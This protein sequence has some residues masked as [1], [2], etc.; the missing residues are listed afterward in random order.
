MINVN[1]N[2]KVPEAKPIDTNG[3]GWTWGK[4]FNNEPIYYGNKFND[5]L[6]CTLIIEMPEERTVNWI[7]YYPY[8]P[9]SSCYVIINDISTSI[10]NSTDYKTCIIDVGDRNARIGAD[11]VP[12]LDV[13]DRQKYKGHGVWVFPARTAKFIKFE[14]TIEKPYTENIAHLYWEETY[15]DVYSYSFCGITY[16]KRKKKHKNRIEG[17]GINKTKIEDISKDYAKEMQDK[18]T[19]TAAA[20]I[21]ASVGFALGPLT[22][23]AVALTSMLFSSKVERKNYQVKSGLDIYSDGWRWCLGIKGID[24]YSYIYQEKSVFMSKNFTLD[25]P[26]KEISLSVSEMIPVEFYQDDWAT[27]NQWI[28][29]YVSIDDGG[30]WYQI[31]PLERTPNGG[32]ESFP[33]KVV[34]VVSAGVEEESSNT[35]T[36]IQ[37]TE[38]VKQIKLMAELNRPT[39]EETMAALTPIIYDYQ[40]RILP[41]EEVEL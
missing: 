31:S 1:E 33:P 29:Y 9:N 27:S 24:V 35:K 23:L 36:Y 16:S 21:M 4:E 32:E 34:S 41:R 40:L 8:F 38:D 7:D 6:K 26:I 19:T 5:S 22:A 2:Y 15:T 25:R 20:A 14:F 12:G 13:K 18:V 39:K 10:N 30:H 37:A 11:T 17:P 3:C 28:K